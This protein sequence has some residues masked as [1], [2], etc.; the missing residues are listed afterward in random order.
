[1]RPGLIKTGVNKD[2]AAARDRAQACSRGGARGAQSGLTVASHTGPAAPALEEL[3]IIQAAGLA[4]GRFIW[5]HAHNERDHALHHR[6]AK[7]GVWVEFDGLSGA[8]RIGIS[9]VCARWPMPDCSARRCF[10]RTPAGTGPALSAARVTAAIRTCS[11]PAPRL[12][13]EG[14]S[15][16]DS[17]NF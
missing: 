3:D 5:V 7:E 6:L 11:R 16:A 15:Q 10:R 14:F 8:R 4:P 17:I 9:S 12:V 2:G 1:M 13:R